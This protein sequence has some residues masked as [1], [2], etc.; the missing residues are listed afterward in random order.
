[1]MIIEWEIQG[2]RRSYGNS[3]TETNAIEI[4]EMLIRRGIDVNA[5]D[6]V[7]L[8]DIYGMSECL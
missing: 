7:L 5:Q 1:M 2:A 8:C 6:D 4:A 3:T